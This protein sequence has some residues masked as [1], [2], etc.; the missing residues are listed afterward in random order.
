MR[1]SIIQYPNPIL[2]KVSEPVIF[3]NKALSAHD[4]RIAY[5][6]TETLLV[7]HAEGKAIGLSAPQI[8]YNIRILTMFVHKQYTMINPEILKVSNVMH[9]SEEGCLSFPGLRSI[10]ER[11]K[12]VKV[13]YTDMQ[14]VNHTIKLYDLEA[15]CFQHELDHLDGIL[16]I[17][18]EIK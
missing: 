10:V 7:M 15:K 2:L 11:P 12:T 3:V 4:R 13:Q 17:N 8:G 18:K 6:L 16:M 1:L 9:P 5:D 14:G